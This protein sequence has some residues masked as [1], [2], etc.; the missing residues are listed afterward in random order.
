M[1]MAEV[2]RA[3]KEMESEETLIIDA[4]SA[5]KAK[6]VVKEEIKRPERPSFNNVIKFQASSGFWET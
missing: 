4:K 5:S 3:D 1:M 2:D 6:A